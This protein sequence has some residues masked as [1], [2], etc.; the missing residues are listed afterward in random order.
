MKFRDKL[1]KLTEGKTRSVIADA[2]KLKPGILNNFFNRDN[3]EPMAST[4]LKLSRALEVPLD[5]LV[6]D[7]A[8]WP[9][10]KP[11]EPQDVP[12][13]LLIGEL[14][15]RCHIDVLEVLSAF[16]ALDKQD[17]RKVLEFANKFKPGDTV[18][19]EFAEGISAVIAAAE[20][21]LSPRR[22]D[23]DAVAVSLHDSL[24][25][26]DRERGTVTMGAC[27]QK[28]AEAL[29]RPGF[30]DLAEWM[31]RHYDVLAA[32]GLR[33]MGN[34]VGFFEMG[35]GF[36]PRPTIIPPPHT[37]ARDGER[38]GKLPPAEKRKPRAKDR[39]SKPG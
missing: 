12:Y 4:A 23:I 37:T 30:R 31:D 17:F 5:W 36:D 9:P 8:G 3:S 38:T 13:S 32:A 25:G 11:R 34:I 22:Y 7:E 14:A 10:P 26:K 19:D 29:N 21:G 2:A 16:D 1:L 15:R 28:Y 35:A 20:R 24:P 18:P 39:E 33:P 27:R 6:D